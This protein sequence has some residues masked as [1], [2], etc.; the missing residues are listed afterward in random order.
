[1]YKYTHTYMQKDIS[2]Y[3]MIQIV[4]L[5]NKALVTV[6]VILLTLASQMFLAL[7]C[8]SQN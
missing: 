4:G 3:D 1:M 2:N 6:E 7:N 8:L 5:S